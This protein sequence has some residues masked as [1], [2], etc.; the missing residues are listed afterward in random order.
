LWRLALV[1]LAAALS[2]MGAVIALLNPAMLVGPHAE[3]NA[4]VHTYA[5]YLVSRNLV[6]AAVLIGL[7]V[8]R[9]WRPLGLMMAVVGLIQVVDAAVDCVEGRWAVAPGVLVLGVVFLIAASG[10]SGGYG[11]W[12]REAWM[13]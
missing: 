11:F 13:G 2:G 12:R 4:A 7:L 1:I 8:A 5:G 6:I 3:I 10:L 9:L